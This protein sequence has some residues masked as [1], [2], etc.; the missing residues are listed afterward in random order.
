MGL[1]DRLFGRAAPAA[2]DPLLGRALDRTV[3]LV[4]PRLALTRDWQAKLAPGVSAAIEVARSVALRLQ[5]VHD[6]APGQWANDAT[7]RALFPAADGIHSVLG[8]ARELQRFLRARAG[9]TEAFAVLGA[10]FERKQVLGAAL[11]DGTV[12][13]DVALQ[14]AA[15][16]GHELKAVAESL[17]ALRQAAGSR[18]F[19][20]LLLAATRR[21]AEADKR[22]DD[23]NVTRAML[24]ARL[25][26]LDAGEGTLL[27][28]DDGAEAPDPALER[29][30]IRQRLAQI[31]AAIVAGGGGVDGLDRQ[32]EIVRDTLLGARDSIRIAPC[33]LWLDAM[34]RVVAEGAA[35]GRPVSVELATFGARSQAFLA[36]RVQRADVPAGGLALAAVER[37][38]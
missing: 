11:V 24:Q 19:N 28:A 30:E 36:V 4:D 25:R 16:A 7:L 18:V 22:N 12:R 23:L 33:V 35:D 10:R 29:A 17:D 1:L 27:E 20:D 2:A 8:R 38:L 26:L 15:F 32:L 3:E 5:T 9:A 34:N 21:L 37:S 14:E 13:Q 6:L 31:Q